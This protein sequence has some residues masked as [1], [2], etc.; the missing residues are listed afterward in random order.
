[1]QALSSTC[2]PLQSSTIPMSSP[3]Y[4]LHLGHGCYSLKL[5]GHI[6]AH[7][8]L[9]GGR[10]LWV[11]NG[12]HSGVV[13]QVLA[14]LKHA[15]HDICHQWYFIVVIATRQ[16][17]RHCNY[18]TTLTLYGKTRGTSPQHISFTH[19]HYLPWPVDFLATSH[20]L[21]LHLGCPV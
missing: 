14:G 19:Y 18:F 2:L 8:S 6:I 17:N 11:F 1:M 9:Q 13:L 7:V 15:L 5:T 20:C 12:T 4:V 21:F 10:A 3:Q 16:E